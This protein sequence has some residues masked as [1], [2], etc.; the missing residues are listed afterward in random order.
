MT[1]VSHVVRDG[2]TIEPVTSARKVQMS[3]V[4]GYP[5]IGGLLR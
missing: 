5:P 3:G 4:T 1:G 2:V